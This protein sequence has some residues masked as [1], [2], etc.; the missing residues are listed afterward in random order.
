VNSR[1]TVCGRPAAHVVIQDIID[2]VDQPDEG[3]T[4]LTATVGSKTFTLDRGILTQ[5]EKRARKE[6]RY[7][8]FASR[9]VEPSLIRMA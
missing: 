7:I 4:H 5:L 3:K 6:F 2:L 8:L 9:H 1:I